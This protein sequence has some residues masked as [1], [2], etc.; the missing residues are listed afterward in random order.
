M[1][2]FCD[3]CDS[4]DVAGFADQ[5]CEICEHVPLCE[6]CMDFHANEMYEE[7]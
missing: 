2:A 6:S 3:R 1:E 7:F 5:V 4:E